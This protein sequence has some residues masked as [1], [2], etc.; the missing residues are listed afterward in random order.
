MSPIFTNITK[1]TN[2]LSRL[3]RPISL[4]GAALLAQA[5]SLVAVRLVDGPAHHIVSDSHNEN[6]IKP[7]IMLR[8]SENILWALQLF[9]Y[10]E[11]K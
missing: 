8:L 7:L 4:V 10:R 11:I 9:S 5:H 3:V 2:H 1:K 6:V